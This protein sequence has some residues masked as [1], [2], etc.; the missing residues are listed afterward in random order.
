MSNMLRVEVNEVGEVR[1]LEGDRVIYDWGP[2]LGAAEFVSVA[3]NLGFEVE[4]V[5]VSA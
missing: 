4:Y 1:I 3:R 2:D 5:E